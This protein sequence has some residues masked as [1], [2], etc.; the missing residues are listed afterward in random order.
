MKVRYLTNYDFTNTLDRTTLKWAKEEESKLNKTSNFTALYCTYVECIEDSLPYHS[1]YEFNSS[2]AFQEHL[3]GFIGFIY[4]ELD[5]KLSNKYNYSYETNKVFKDL[6]NELGFEKKILNL[7]SNKISDDVQE[8]IEIYKNQKHKE[9]RKK[10]FRG[11][12][13]QSNDKKEFYLN[14][15]F[16]YDM[17]GK[18]FTAE[19][20]KAFL[21][22]GRNNIATTL[23][24]K[25]GFLINFFKLLS[26]TFTNLKKLKNAMAAE[27]VFSTMLTIYNLG[28]I[29]AK[30]NDYN[31]GH[32]H[33][34]WSCIVDLYYDLVRIGIWDE[35]YTDILSPRYKAN[36]KK[37]TSVNLIKNHQSEILHNKLVTQI[38]L[39]YT[40][41]QAK[42]IIFDKIKKDID[43][44]VYCAKKKTS[45]IF[46]EYQ[47][48][49][50]ISSLGEVKKYIPASIKYDIPIGKDSIPNTY[51]TYLHY[52]FKHPIIKSYYSFLK[53]GIKDKNVNIIKNNIFYSN[54][55][56]IYPFLIMLIN[57]HQEITESWLLNWKLKE[58]NR[59]TGLFQIGENWYSKSYKKRRGYKHAEQIIKLNDNSKRIIEQ[60]I[61]ITSIARDYLT[62]NNHSDKDYMLL[63][64]TTAFT[65][66]RKVI[67]IENTI[68]S[69]VNRYLKEVFEIQ[70]YDE[71]RRIITSKEEAENIFRNLTLTKFR[72]SCAVRVYLETMSVH[73]MSIALGHKE[74][75]HKLIDSYLPDILWKYFTHRWIRIF[76]NALIY[77][78]MKNSKYLYDSVDFTYE[79]LNDF[80]KNHAFEEIPYHIKK[81]YHEIEIE[82]QLN[83]DDTKYI[84]IF[85]ITIPLLQIFISIKKYFEKYKNSIKKDTLIYYW[86]ICAEYVIEQINLSKIDQSNGSFIQNEIVKMY[87]IAEK[88]PI[89]QNFIKKVFTHE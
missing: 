64:S 43:H 3:K 30:I 20:Y 24:K 56:K 40:D 81:G 54:Y 29:E 10:Y 4:T 55:Q 17:Y 37:H 50:Q 78:S 11:W 18:E 42:L 33:N 87:N 2:R 8:C 26:K 19:I 61:E 44:I 83:D 9:D 1:I 74:Y 80:I 59:N 88:N 35:P 47:K 6:A 38:P 77:E 89:N 31:I 73:K 84:G 14:I 27:N 66:P 45:E 51:R 7:S 22:I 13:I 12:R 75:S 34:R 16:I 32:Y 49:K 76:Q 85:P 62:K 67:K 21:Q 58:E 63:I 68:Y 82:K 48:F 53:L 65:E 70:T 57:E 5:C 23:S 46:D 72:A 39:S 86:Y 79:Q 28:L 15:S 36:T 69:G 25:I 52:P 41:D 71:T 60:I